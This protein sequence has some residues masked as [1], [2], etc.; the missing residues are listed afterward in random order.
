MTAIINR[1]SEKGNQILEPTGLAKPS[2]THG[3]T[4]TGMGLARKEAQGQVFG[5]V[6]NQAEPFV[7]ANPALLAGYP[8]RL[9]T[10][11]ATHGR[12]CNSALFSASLV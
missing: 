2:K 10:L 12:R 9:L 8:D 11:A 3:L 4:C 1:K 7:R 6:W 5:R